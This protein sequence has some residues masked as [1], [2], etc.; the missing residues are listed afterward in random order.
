MQPDTVFPGATFQ[1][2]VGT[3][4]ITLSAPGIATYTSPTLQ[5]LAG[6]A[7]KLAFTT[8]PAANASSGA[9]LSPQPVVQVT[10]IGGNAVNA[11]GLRWL[12]R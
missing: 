12:R 5:V 4:V 8:P 7:A 1:G 3:G 11:A 6:A 9:P 10:D 2:L